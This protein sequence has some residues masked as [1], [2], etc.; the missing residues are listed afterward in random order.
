VCEE[1]GASVVDV[2]DRDLV[3]LDPAAR[4]TPI[5]AA[6]GALLDDLVAARRGLVVP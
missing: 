1:A 5:A 6:T 3:V 2:D 4:R